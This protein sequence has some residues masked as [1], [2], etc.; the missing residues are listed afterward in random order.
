MTRLRPARRHRPAHDRRQPARLLPDLPDVGEPEHVARASSTLARN[1][2]FPVVT[3]TVKAKHG[4][5]YFYYGNISRQG[6]RA[7][8]NDLELYKPRYTQTYFGIRNRLGILVETY[9]YA[10]FEDRIKANYW[11]LEEMI[12]FAVK[13]AAAIRKATSR[14]GRRVDRRQAA[15]GAR[16]A[17]EGG[18]AGAG[19]PGRHGGGAEPVRARPA[20]AAPRERQREDRGDAALRDGGADRDQRRAARLRSAE[21]PGAA[22]PRRPPAPPSAAAAGAP[23]PAAA[24][25]GRAVRLPGMGGGFG[26]GGAPAASLGERASIAST[27][28]GVKFFRTSTGDDGQGR[29]LPHR[30]RTR[31]DAGVPATTSCA[32]SPASGRRPS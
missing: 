28:H 15:V 29:A 14:G 10:T 8:Y 3:K 18:G 2:L 1:E 4:W 31:R 5:D 27:A 12:D 23:P 22:T 13:H 11:F 24:A 30:S 20:D 9:S 16:Q 6:E 32:R 21:R 19:G 7:W 25:R 17:G 26:R